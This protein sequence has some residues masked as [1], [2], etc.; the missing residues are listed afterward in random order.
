VAD[1]VRRRSQQGAPSLGLEF[2]GET[3]PIDW[4]LADVHL[5][6][7][8]RAL[9]PEIIWHSDGVVAAFPEI[10]IESSPT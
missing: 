9:E 7:K 6:N 4:V 2:R 8:P 1:R 10:V 3:S 5:E